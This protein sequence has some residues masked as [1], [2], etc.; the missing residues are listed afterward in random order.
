[1]SFSR[2][3]DARAAS[4]AGAPTPDILFSAPVLL[5]GRPVRWLDA[6]NYCYYG[7]PL[8]ARSLAAQA[9]KYAR[10]FGPG[11]FV[12]RHGVDPAAPPLGPAL[13]DGGGIAPLDRK[14]DVCESP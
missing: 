1:V 6:K 5:G 3:A 10:A 9:A 7:S 14:G 13:L 2:E 11:A 12:F 4:P 8:T